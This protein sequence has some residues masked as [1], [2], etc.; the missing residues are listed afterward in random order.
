MPRKGSQPPKERRKKN[1]LTLTVLFTLL[2]DF[3]F[4]A[5]LLWLLL[6][7]LQFAG[8]FITF[9]WGLAFVV[10]VAVIIIKLMFK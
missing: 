3:L 2:L 8:V 7:V 1:M 10:W 4:T 6:F 9:T 5:G